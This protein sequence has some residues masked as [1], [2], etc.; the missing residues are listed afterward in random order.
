MTLACENPFTSLG[1]CMS[2][3]SR[4]WGQDKR[5][6]WM[7]GIICGW[8]ERSMQECRSRFGWSD[9][10]VARLRRLRQRFMGL[11]VGTK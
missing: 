3:H 4:D 6:A 9:E 1:N 5:D 11:D 2:F 10:D 8:D 7:W